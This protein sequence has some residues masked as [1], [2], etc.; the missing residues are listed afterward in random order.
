ML[1][2]SSG[3]VRP[4]GCGLH[5]HVVLLAVALVARDLAPAQH[6]LQRAWPTASTPTPMSAALV[7]VDVDAQLG[8]VQAQVDVGLRRC[9]GSWRSRRASAASTPLRFCVAV[10][11]LDHEVD[12]PVAEALAQRRRRDRECVDARQRANLRLQLARQSPRACACGRP[13][14]LCGRRT[15]ACDDRGIARRCRR[16][17][18]TPGTAAPMLLQRVARSGRCSPAWTPSGAVTV[19]RI[20]P[21]SSIGDSSLLHGRVD[22][23]IARR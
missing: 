12:R 7:A 9:P 5:D 11:G 13:S 18:R 22:S 19:A 10:G 4:G 23:A 16:Y 1:S 14:R 21:R 15:L 20:T 17:G 8:L 2:M 6:G 3:V